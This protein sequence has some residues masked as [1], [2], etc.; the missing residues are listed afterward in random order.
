M[1]IAATIDV[2]TNSVLLLIGERQ[3]DNSVRVLEDL[4]RVTRLGEGVAASG[5][6]AAAAAERTMAALRE[7]R[8]RCRELGVADVAAVGTAALRNAT[9]AADFLDRARTELGLTIEV[10]SS[11]REAQLTYRAASHDFGDEIVVVDIGGGSTEFIAQSRT[12]ENAASELHLISLPIGCVS[13]T[14]RLAAHDPVTTPELHVLRMA[15]HET[16]GSELDLHEFAHPHDLKLVATA[17]T[18]TT[19][20]A[21]HLELAPYDPAR[22]HGSCLK[23]TDLRD[24]MNAISE[25][26][27]EERRRMPGLLPE[28]ADVILAGAVL[29]HEVMSTLG[30]AEVTISDRGVKW[31]LFYEKFCP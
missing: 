2:G 19:L 20:A 4:A 15:V 29:L 11:E 23:V 7:Y 12:S 28:R 21:M 6:L 14:E 17:G 10:I 16:L 8:A 13:L 3:S 31:G 18:A 25:K 24:L 1:A 5:V 9:T 30:Y 26:T 22:V 27:L